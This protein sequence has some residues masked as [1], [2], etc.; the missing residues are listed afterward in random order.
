MNAKSAFAAVY[1]FAAFGLSTAM[2]VPTLT[3]LVSTTSQNNH[4]RRHSIPVFKSVDELI[5]KT[6]ILRLRNDI[7]IRCDSSL[8]SGI[9]LLEIRA[10]ANGS[11]VICWDSI[12][13]KTLHLAIADCGHTIRRC[14]IL[15]SSDRFCFACC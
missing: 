5:E 10:I 14:W 11:S 7:I 9:I 8:M 2:A 13:C 15:V 3:M 6:V 12:T 1:V 4:S